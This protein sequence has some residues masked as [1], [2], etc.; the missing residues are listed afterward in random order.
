MTGLVFAGSSGTDSFANP[1]TPFAPAFTNPNVHEPLGGNVLDTADLQRIVIMAVVGDPGQGYYRSY[2][3][4]NAGLQSALTELALDGDPD[5]SYV[6]Y[7]GADMTSGISD[8]FANTGNPGT[9]SGLRGKV[10]GIILTGNAQDLITTTALTAASQASGHRQFTSD[11]STATFGSHLIVRNLRYRIGSRT[12]MNGFDLTIAGNTWQTAASTYYGGDVSGTVTP[13]QNTVHLTAYSTGTGVSS[14]IGGMDTGTLNGNTAITIHG[15]S[16]NSI[17]I[18]GGG[19]G[20]GT[21]ATSQ[22][23]VTGNVS[24]T[25]TALNAQS[26]GLRSF[27]GGTNFGDIGG[28]I[29]TTI[30]GP[31]R[32]AANY[33]TATGA[34]IADGYFVGGS[35][36][37]SIGTARPQ[38]G[39][40]D[41]TGLA[42]DYAPL[43]TIDDYAILNNIDTSEYSFGRL[44]Y[45]G[46][47]TQSGTVTGNVV[48]IMKAGRGE[49]GSYSG[50]QG[51]GGFAARIGGGFHSGAQSFTIDG[52]TGT[53]SN[54]EAGRARAESMADFRLY[55]NIV[56]VV[57]EGS[58]SMGAGAGYFRGAG[59]GGYVEGD[60]FSAVGTEG[61]AYQNNNSNYTYRVSLTGGGPWQGHSTSFDL[62]GGGGAESQHDSICIV[63]NTHL[64]QKEV[65]AR[66]TYGGMFGGVLLGSSKIE[67]HSGVVDTLE[68]AGYNA[69]IQYGDGRSEVHGGQVDWFLCGGSWN[70]EWHDGNVSVEVMDAPPPHSP[71]INASMGGTYGLSGQT[72]SG[73]SEIMV[74]GGDFRGLPRDGSPGFSTGPSNAGTIFG[75]SKMTID[76]RGNQHGFATSVANTI[77]AGRRVGAGA[78]IV[79]GTNSD[80]TIELNIFTDDEGTDLLSGMNIYGDSGTPTSNT[81]SGKITFNINAPGSSIGNLF[82]TNYDNL[83]GTGQRRLMRD[84]EINLVSAATINGL[85]SGNGFT[86][87]AATGNTLNNSTVANSAAIGRQA[88]INIG[89]QSDNPDDP[90]GERDTNIPANGRPRVI[91]VG[92]TGV[93]GFTEMDINRRI[94]SATA[95]SVKNGG[96]RAA[97]GTFNEY[98]EFGH[99]TLHAGEGIDAAGFGIVPSAA[100]L[101]VAG[102]LIVKGA[103]VAYI[104]SPGAQDQA[105]FTDAHVDDTLIWLRIGN[106]AASTFNPV[107]SWFGSTSGWHVFTV[108]PDRSNA[109]KITPFNL[110]GLEDA[111]GRTF[112]GDNVIPGTGNNGFAVAIPANIYRWNV[113]EGAGMISHNVE[114]TTSTNMPSAGNHLN[115]VGTVAKNTPSRSGRIAIPSDRIPDPINSPTFSFIPDGP[116]GEWTRGVQIHRSDCLLTAPQHVNRCTTLTEDDLRAYMADYLD[117]NLPRIATWTA[118]GD[119][120]YF[121]FDITAQYKND[122][123][124]EARSVIITEEEAAAIAS[125]RDV[126]DYTQAAGR[127]FFAHQIDA[128]FLDVLRTPLDSGQY[129]RPHPTEY[130]AGGAGPDNVANTEQKSLTVTI[131][132]VH[133]DSVLA[134]D[135]SYGIYA[136]DALM[137]LHT[138][139]IIDRSGLD[140]QYTKAL[141]FDA[142][143]NTYTP[144]ISPADV[145]NSINALTEAALPTGF[146]ITYSYAPAERPPV[147]KDILVTV[148]FEPIPTDLTLPD[149]NALYLI[150]ICLGFCGLAVPVL[151]RKKQQDYRL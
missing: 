140:A 104:Q 16:G 78:G 60:V 86:G 1:P 88:I 148:D 22:A 116:L 42:E 65:R 8:R 50:F 111:T 137:T 59:Y 46:A 15:S 118:Q 24:T 150:T 14:F 63:G 49:Q 138:A 53:V 62:V 23:H 112:I 58:I 43:L 149:N 9:F 6:F 109:A 103:G 29:T 27:A 54:I 51:G 44:Y 33:S 11:L 132:V 32:M 79:L 115:A 125:Y 98:N 57:R 145:M 34:P 13:P 17:D 93:T 133:N 147:E 20:T 143:G 105:I 136:R 128:A 67:L 2:A 110:E 108:N 131:T 36:A 75:S 87:T 141:A 18:R 71:I 129:V 107:T 95:G 106:A 7:F 40:I 28:N 56:N 55:G 100:S 85:S 90:L 142:Q 25:I 45:V 130:R 77:S 21:G 5:T 72:I 68:G 113:T 3:S 134:P 139:Q 74:R 151:L 80:N 4:G 41:T 124:L 64:I 31:G 81:R 135:R 26:G 73:D 126:L 117:G 122:T 119:D 123:Q 70:D 121:A 120:R 92:G 19:N 114:V 82:A 66:W 102:E 37:G 38:A 69:F 84:V 61:I 76:L 52:G 10:H 101:I 99:I 146:N 89:P 47:N 144:D 39:K 12:F 97:L 48:N 30:S 83:E 94:L 35:R 127:P 91:N 96:T